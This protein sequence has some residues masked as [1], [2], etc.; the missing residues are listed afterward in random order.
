MLVDVAGHYGGYE[1]LII[2]WHIVHA[3][4]QSLVSGE[5]IV[6][7]P[8]LFLSDRPHPAVCVCVCVC[9]CGGLIQYLCV[10]KL[11][12]TGCH[13]LFMYYSI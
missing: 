5:L 11:S 8:F 4:L 1:L 10:V 12:V 2:E 13:D 6:F 9:V 3:G 7:L